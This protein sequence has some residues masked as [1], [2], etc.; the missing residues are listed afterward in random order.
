MLELRFD[1]VKITHF[2]ESDVFRAVKPFLHDPAARNGK[3]RYARFKLEDF[4]GAAE[5]VM[6]PEDYDKYK[7]LVEEDKICFVG[8]ASSQ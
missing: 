3:S 7:D 4:S 8:G 1:Q 5:C 2:Q 6:W